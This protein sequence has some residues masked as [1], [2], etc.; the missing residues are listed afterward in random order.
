MGSPD[1]L[2]RV[3]GVIAR[4]VAVRDLVRPRRV[5]GPGAAGVGQVGVAYMARVERRRE[6]DE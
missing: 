5:E 2:G 6:R 4:G 3:N 1:A